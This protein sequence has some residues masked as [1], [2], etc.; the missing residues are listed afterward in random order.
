MFTSRAMHASLAIASRRV[1]RISRVTRMS[2]VMRMSSVTRMSGAIRAH[3][4]THR[5]GIASEAPATPRSPIKPDDIVRRRRAL[6][7]KDPIGPRVL[8]PRTIASALESPGARESPATYALGATRAKTEPVVPTP[9]RVERRP[10]AARIA[11][12]AG[13]TLPAIRA[14]DRQ[15]LAN[16]GIPSTPAK[17]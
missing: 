14:P 12:T 1:M 8:I 4:A 10:S 13:R 3:R 16:R 17:Q 2:G 7:G 15:P 9:P 6:Q 5:C 11:R